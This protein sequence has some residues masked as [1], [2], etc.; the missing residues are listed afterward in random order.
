LSARN[1]EGLAPA[2]TENEALNRSADD[3][4]EIVPVVAENTTPLQAPFNLE[5]A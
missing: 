2:Y 4:G 5:G 1:G 3:L